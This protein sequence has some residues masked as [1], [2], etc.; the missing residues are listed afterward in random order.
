[1]KLVNIFHFSVKKIGFLRK[2]C[3]IDIFSDFE[4][5]RQKIARDTASRLKIMLHL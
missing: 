2:V 3:Q 5:D 4:F 1:M